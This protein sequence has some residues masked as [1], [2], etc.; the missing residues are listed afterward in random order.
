MS[1]T[2]N[3]PNNQATYTTDRHGEPVWCSKCDRTPNGD[4][5]DGPCG[6]LSVATDCCADCDDRGPDRLIETMSN[7]TVAAI[8]IDADGEP[9]SCAYC[10][11]YIK[12]GFEV[13]S[14]K[15]GAEGLR[16]CGHT[17]SMFHDPDTARRQ[18][19]AR[20]E[21]DQQREGT[22]W[23]AADLED[24]DADNV[25]EEA[26]EWLFETPL[27][28]FVMDCGTPV[29][30]VGFG[31]PFHAIKFNDQGAR[32]SFA[33]VIKPRRWGVPEMSA[34]ATGALVDAIA[35][36]LTDHFDDHA[37]GADACGECGAR[38][39]SADI[40]GERRCVPCDFEDFEDF[41]DEDLE[42]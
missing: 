41:E 7:V 31:G 13:R 39:T 34:V 2:P 9:L 33:T 28:L 3:T 30:L 14:T 29:A 4:E 19:E 32:G 5:Y 6:P 16:Y 12:S 36:R 17:C 1:K 38:M 26:E 21:F 10:D 42:D 27:D 23:E 20:L 15:R 37:A 25:E 22:D 11:D 35:A 8:A 40:F 24:F 18:E